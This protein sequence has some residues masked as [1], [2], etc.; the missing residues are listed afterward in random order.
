MVKHQWILR[1]EKGEKRAEEVFRYPLWQ[2]KIA[3]LSFDEKPSSYQGKSCFQRHRENTG[4]DRDGL[5]SRQTSQKWNLSEDH[6]HLHHKLGLKQPSS[7]AGS[8][9][10]TSLPDWKRTDSECW[11]PLWRKELG[12]EIEG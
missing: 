11:R 4:G 1:K 9:V 7:P 3:C 5:A 10:E 6:H 12:K 2:V 8:P